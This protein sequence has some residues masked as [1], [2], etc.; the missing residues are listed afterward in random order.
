[1]IG[2]SKLSGTVI[3]PSKLSGPVV[4]PSK[5][6]AKT[7]TRPEQSG[8]DD[9]PSVA[10]KTAQ[11]IEATINKSIET[12]S[13]G[14]LKSPVVKSTTP[15]NVKSV[16]QSLFKSAQMSNLNASRSVQ[17]SHLPISIPTP[18]SVASLSKIQRSSSPATLRTPHSISSGIPKS[19]QSY[20]GS[21]SGS[22]LRPAVLKSI[23]S[24]I[25]AVVKAAAQNS[26][27]EPT[28]KPI[29]TSSEQ[30]STE[31]DDTPSMNVK[32]IKTYSRLTR[33]SPSNANKL[34]IA[35]TAS[36]V[37]KQLNVSGPTSGKLPVVTAE[38]S[39]LKQPI[40]NTASESSLVKQTI[41]GTP[42]S[43]G[44]QVTASN[45]ANTVKVPTTP[46]SSPKTTTGNA[47]SATKASTAAGSSAT[48]STV[49]I[50]AG[51]PKTSEKKLGRPPKV[52]TVVQETTEATA[53]EFEV[54][55][56]SS[57]RLGASTR[58]EQK[59]DS[60]EDDQSSEECEKVIIHVYV[61]HM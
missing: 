21:K 59:D 33:H 32:D 54:K 51:S 9:K 19:V 38:S 27:S 47:S 16:N 8:S 18:S 52:A 34:A 60:D 49:G 53:V 25:S 58:E 40:D 5:K 2:P 37:A 36:N 6:S 20:S 57:S 10:E 28:P 45:A 7:L 56:R 42:S 11:L 44:R 1:M 41:G 23:Q 3:G 4:G 15:S 31:D 13:L 55:T 48:K 30:K 29:P 35:A 22:G 26:A 61:N 17:A 43:T 39:L 50:P 14:D 12:S 24:S 46:G